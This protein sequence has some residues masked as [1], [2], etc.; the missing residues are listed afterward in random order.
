MLIDRNGLEVLGR[1]ACLALLEQAAFGRVGVSIG[2]LPSVLPVNFRLVGDTI[3]FR[4]GAGS[5]LHAATAGAV[6]AFEVDDVDPLDHTGWSVVVTGV[7]EERPGLD[8]VVAGA[9][10]RWAPVGTTRVLALPTDVI[11]GRRISRQATH[12]ASRPA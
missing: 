12:R 7:A 1:D 5:K 11:S 9:V 2:A 10:P 3:V 4:T 6:I 8:P